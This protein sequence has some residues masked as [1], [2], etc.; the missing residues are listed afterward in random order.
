MRKHLA[1]LALALGTLALTAPPVSAAE[2]GGAVFGTIWFDEN[3]DGVRQPGEPPVVGFQLMLN[4]MYTGVTSTDENG[5]YRFDDKPAGVYFVAPYGAYNAF[6]KKGA[7]SVFDQFTGRSDWIRV[8]EGGEAGP[9]NG[10]L[11]ERRPDSAVVNVAVPDELPVGSEVKIEVTWRNAGNVPETLWGSA[12]LPDGLTPV[13]TN[14]P[15]DRIDGQRA[16]LSSMYMPP[17]R[18]GESVTY[19]VY[20]RVDSE[21]VRG[22]YFVQVVNQQDINQK[23]NIWRATVRG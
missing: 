11:V 2:A 19:T 9:I 15:V 8:V 18:Q 12:L 5:N 1:V 13:S 6:T 14:A 22:H 20:A 4:S 23:N 16:H 17:T 21:D 7:D 10:G 3:E